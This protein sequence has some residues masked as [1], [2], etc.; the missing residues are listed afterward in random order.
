MTTVKNHLYLVAFAI[1]MAFAVP[2]AVNADPF[3]DCVA[4]CADDPS[5]HACVRACVVQYGTPVSR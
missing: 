5:D 1:G 4:Q 2:G 3:G